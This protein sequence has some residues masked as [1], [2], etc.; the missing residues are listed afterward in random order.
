[1][2]A[3]LHTSSKVLAASSGAFD[4]GHFY[5]C[6][7]SNEHRP[8]DVIL[9]NMLI[10]D[11]LLNYTRPLIYTISLSNAAIIAGSCSFDLLEDGTAEKVLSSSRPFAITR[12]T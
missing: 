12:S 11:Y 8:S 3:W 2:L 6:T 10:R 7:T 4:L 9:T 1:M 5:P